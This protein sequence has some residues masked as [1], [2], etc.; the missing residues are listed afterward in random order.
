MGSTYLVSALDVRN[1]ALKGTIVANGSSVVDGTGS[2]NCGPGCTETGTNRR[3]TDGLA[4]RI[5]GE[6]PPDQ[7]LAVANAG[8]GGT[9]SSDACGPSSTHRLDALAR[10]DRDVLA[11][12]GVTAVIYYYGTND[13]ANGCT[14][15]AILTSYREVFARLHDAGIKAYVT[16]ITLAPRTAT[17]TTATATR[18][19]R[20]SRSGAAARA[21]VTAWSISTRCSRIR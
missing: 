11:L 2:T 21:P 9:T 5:A 20:S 18:S 17:R 19:A 8:I 14:A 10:L 13:L 4:R 16:P 1:P 3:W 15:E 7:Q 12:H 6:L